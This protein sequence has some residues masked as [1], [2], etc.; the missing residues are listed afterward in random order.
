MKSSSLSEFGCS[1]ECFSSVWCIFR[2]YLSVSNNSDNASGWMF[3]TSHC[4]CWCCCCFCCHLSKSAVRA[5]SIYRFDSLWLRMNSCRLRRLRSGCRSGGTVT[6]SPNLAQFCFFSIFCRIRCRRHHS[7][8]WYD[9][10]TAG[11]FYSINLWR[12]PLVH[13]QH[14]GY[15]RRIRVR[16]WDCPSRLLLPLGFVQCWRFNWFYDL[17]W[18]TQCARG[19]DFVFSFLLLMCVW[20][21]HVVTA[22]DVQYEQTPPHIYKYL[23]GYVGEWVNEGMGD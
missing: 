8:R 19:F 12:I 15:S 10:A 4:S 21:C 22:I 6:L 16:V 11:A 20:G 13:L 3:Y 1:S 2:R 17:V 9:A 7:R 5:Y 14:A 23:H 18:R